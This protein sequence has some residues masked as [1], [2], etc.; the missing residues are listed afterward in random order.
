MN[1]RSRRSTPATTLFA[2][3]ARY[4]MVVAATVAM[5]VISAGPGTQ[6]RVAGASAAPPSGTPS[7]T[8]PSATLHFSVRPEMAAIVGGTPMS[9]AVTSAQ[10]GRE[11]RVELF[12]NARV[13]E[14]GSTRRIAA[15]DGG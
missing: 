8:T 14:H 10:C 5:L 11:P 13:F 7:S 3:L 15:R 4:L 2:C 6:A 9:L 1:H 12:R